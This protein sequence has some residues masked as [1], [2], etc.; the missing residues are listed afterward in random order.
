[1]T[2]R[3]HHLSMLGQQ[4]CQQ[5]AALTA[6]RQRMTAI[7]GITFG[8]ELRRDDGIGNESRREEGIGNESRRGR[9]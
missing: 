5:N 9:G 2:W 4:Y 7:R 6:K 8:N 3:Q 1:M